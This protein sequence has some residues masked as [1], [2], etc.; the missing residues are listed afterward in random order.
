MV[1]SLVSGST[2]GATPLGSMGLPFGPFG[3]DARIVLDSSGVGPWASVKT[4]SHGC[5]GFSD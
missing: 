5:A 2:L 1:P 4:E 3:C